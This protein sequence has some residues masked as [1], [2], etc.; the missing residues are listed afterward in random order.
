M[1]IIQDG[2]TSSRSVDLHKSASLRKVLGR[3][4]A[5]AG[6]KWTGGRAFALP[7]TFLKEADLRKSS[8]SDAYFPE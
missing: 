8:R 1:Q 3:A 5:R 2:K 6:K 7:G 4:D